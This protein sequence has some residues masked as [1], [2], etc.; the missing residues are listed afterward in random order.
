M[1]VISQVRILA[2]AFLFLLYALY[3]IHYTLLSILSL[4]HT[5]IGAQV[6]QIHLQI[7]KSLQ[8]IQNCCRYHHIILSKAK[9]LTWCYTH[10]IKSTLLLSHKAL[11]C[12]I[13]HIISHYLYTLHDIF[14]IHCSHSYTTL[15]VM[16]L[17][18]RRQYIRQ[19][20]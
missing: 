7:I 18:E 19:Y 8:S 20:I 5:H 3:I 14:Y 1:A 12:Y 4:S 15:Y 10:K 13:S 9:K 16:L 17:C 6:L 2:Y 11:Q